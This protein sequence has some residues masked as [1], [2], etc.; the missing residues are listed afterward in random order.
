MAYLNKLS[1][2]VKIIVI[3]LA[4]TMIGI[5]STVLIA[6]YSSKTSLM[7]MGR[8]QLNSIGSISKTRAADFIK[9]T[10]TFTM[11]LGKDRLSEGLIFSYD[12]AFLASGKP[13]GKDSDLKGA[14]FTKLNETYKQRVDD[15]VKSYDLERYILVNTQGQ[16]IFNSDFESEGILGGRN[17]FNGAMKDLK[18]SQCV[19]S[20]MK[21]KSN[22]VFYSDTEYNSFIEDIHTAFCTRIV[23]EFDR[24]ADGITKGD[25][26][27]VVLVELDQRHL[28]QLLS[29]RTGMGETGQGYIVGPDLHLR[30]DFFINSQNFNALNSYKNNIKIDNALTQMAKLKD[31]GNLTLI[32]PNG[33]EV[34]ASF[35]N[36]EIEGQKWIVV[37]EKETKEILAPIGDLLMNI[38][39][40][41]IIIIIVL[42]LAGIYFSTSLTRPIVDSI[43]TLKGVCEDL[44]LDSINL[45]TTANILTQTSQTQ[46]KDLQGTVQAIDEISSTVDQNTANARNSA[47]V[48]DSSLV[49]VENGKKVVGKM[50][51]SMSEIN[52]SNDKLLAGVESSNKKLEEIVA[53]ISDIESKTKVINDI[54]FQTKLLSFNASV[55]SA[56]AGEHGKGFAVVAEE[57]GNLASLSGQSAKSISDLLQQSIDRVNIII[58]E[59]KD[60]ING[61]SSETV[62]KVKEG[63]ATADE[64]GKVFEQI[65]VDM[66]KVS[67]MVG[68]I[69]VASNEQ[70]LGM[71]EINKAMNRLND[72]TGKSTEIAEKSSDAANR[73]SSRSESLRGLVEVLHGSIHGQ[74]KS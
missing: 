47:K 19:A 27:G 14:S 62:A 70:N 35:F 54:V 18:I 57:V 66:S 69:S 63:Q 37:A 72:G 48:S 11:L 21:S 33:K 1:F 6:Y 39:L 25:L 64:C 40:I 13:I 22:E 59:T 24:A 42:A 71:S 31:S 28:T 55:E 41:S 68:D 65:L 36:M 67:Q 46:A 49:V 26:L 4:V 34:I 50:I 3:V 74:K 43:E 51:R 23:A 2:R 29:D 45:N 73:L 17:L 8:D 53:L 10:K 61:I 15:Q 7:N 9:R 12:S 60:E 16:V 5:S 30:S 52:K 32:N 44:N 58:K 38:I 56:R 20:A